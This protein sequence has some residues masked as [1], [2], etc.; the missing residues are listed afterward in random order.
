M[1]IFA[2]IKNKTTQKEDKTKHIEDSCKT[3]EPFQQPG[4]SYDSPSA[5]SAVQTE[6]NTIRIVSANM[7]L[8]VVV[9]L[10]T[11]NIN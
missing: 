1:T 8:I 4:R 7:V 11:K 6:M 9:L 5:N 10:S 3:A 2:E